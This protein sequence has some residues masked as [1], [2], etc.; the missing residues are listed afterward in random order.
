MADKLILNADLNYKAVDYAPEKCVVEKVIEVSE[1]EFRKFYEKPLKS[2]YYLAPYKSLMGFYDESY[3]CVLFV[4]RDSGDELLVNS[5]GAD[6]ARYSQFIP[7]AK[8]ILE[9]HEMTNPMRKICDL[10]ALKADEIIH[11]GEQISANIDEILGGLQIYETLRNA[12]YETVR[13]RPEIASCAFENGVISAEKQP[14]TEIKLYCPL[15]FRIEPEDPCDDLDEVDSANYIGYDYEINAAVRADLYSDKDAVERGLAAYFH[16]E[17]LDQKVFSAMPGVETRNGDIYGVITVKS[18]GEL[19]KVEMI[20][21]INDLTG[22]LADGFGEGF[23]QRGKGF[24]NQT[25]EKFPRYDSA[26][27]DKILHGLFYLRQHIP[28]CLGASRV[29]DK[30][31]RTGYT[32]LSRRKRWRNF[33]NLYAPCYRCRGKADHRQCRK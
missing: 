33:A 28:L 29:P 6:Y 13:A 21:L 11:T 16:D 14:L 26:V 24:H 32:S 2:N 12:V 5:E 30:H 7:N 25:A 31:F 20:D 27:R 15:T 18:Y 23:E 9:A 22:N 1:S 8:G 10:I 4:N 17:N 19:S 3:H